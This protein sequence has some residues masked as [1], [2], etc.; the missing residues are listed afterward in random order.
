MNKTQKSLS[1]LDGQQTL[2]SAFNDEDSSMTISGFV[3]GKIGRKIEQTISTTNV[4]N[5]TS[6]LTFTEN[7]TILKIT[8]IIYTDSTRSEWLSVERT[9]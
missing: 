1:Q 7:G 6:T 2:Q 8:K 3:D 5:D 4:A 9:S